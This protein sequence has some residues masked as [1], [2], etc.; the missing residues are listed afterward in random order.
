MRDR[1]NREITYLRM[2]VTDLCNLRCRY[3]MP[4]EGV[5]KLRHE[6]MLTEDEM[7][8]AV[9]TAASLGIRKLRIT[10]GEPLIKK[11]ILSICRRAAEIQGIEELCLTTNGTLLPK[12]AA[13][14][15]S[16]GVDRINISLDTLDPQKYAYMTRGGKL[17]DALDGIET[18]L[19]AGFSKIKINTVLIG[20]FNAEEIPALAELTVKWPVDV[21]FIELMPMPGQ[22]DFSETAFVSDTRVTELMPQLQPLIQSRAVDSYTDQNEHADVPE[23]QDRREK[24][25]EPRHEG[26]AKLWQLPDS[27]GNVG[28]ISPVFDSF[29]GRCNRIRLTADGRLKPCLHSPEE[30]SIKG[31]PQEQIKEQFIRA[32]LKKPECHAQ[33]SYTET[34]H[35]GRSMHAIGG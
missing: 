30:F 20:G 6:D 24:N 10:G 5:C 31:L 9:E 7:I 18:A 21:R 22:N 8:F 26:V 3:C 4:A 23:R 2:S 27:L 1:F 19:Q 34:S 15:R 12:L 25:P 28:L 35:T 17:Q 14:L 13:G 29:C 32:I 33:L 16:A 11:N